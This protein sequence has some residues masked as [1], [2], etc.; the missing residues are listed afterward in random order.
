MADKDKIK[1]VLLDQSGDIP[2]ILDKCRVE[3]VVEPELH[4]ALADTLVKV[5]SGVRRCGKSVLAHRVLKDLPYG[6]VNF[7]D[8]RLADLTSQ[9]RVGSPFGNYA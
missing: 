5:I 7:D 3:R 9:P 4:A 6:Y 8:E 2:G 1:E